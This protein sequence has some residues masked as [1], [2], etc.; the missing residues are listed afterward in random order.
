MSDTTPATRIYTA[1]TAPALNETWT[2]LESAKIHTIRKGHGLAVGAVSVE[3]LWGDVTRDN[4][5]TAV[6]VD[7]P[8]SLNGEFLRITWQDAMDVMQTEFVG[9]ILEPV[10]NVEKSTT[11]MA[12]G[13]L[14]VL[15][16]VHVVSS[17]AMAPLAM[18]QVGSP[19]TNAAPAMRP[20]QRGPWQ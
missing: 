17:T 3:V 7:D 9:R 6:T 12:E 19:P 15:G 5:D 14:S 13:I 2:T 11:L 1:A 18:R 8:A 16:R 4:T 10:P 20:D